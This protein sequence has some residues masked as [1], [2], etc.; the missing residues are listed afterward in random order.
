MPATI[1]REQLVTS[2]LDFLSHQDLLSLA[3]IRA[4]LE[5]EIDGAGSTAL[6][7]LKRQL[8]ADD[9]WNYYP[10]SRLVA[11]IHYLLADHFVR[12]ESDVSGVEHLESIG[13]EPLILCANHLSYADANLVQIL[14]H[15]AGFEDLAQR[16]TALAGPKVFTSRERRFSSL[17]F[18]TVKVP[19]SSDVSSEEAVLSAR[20]VARAARQALSVASQRL[21]A[22]DALVLF[23]EGRRSRSAQMQPMLPAVARY[24]ESRPEAWVVPVGITGTEALFPVGDARVRP[25]RVH[26]RVASPL[27][28]HRV[29]TATNAH[30]QTTMDVV[31]LL[32]ADLL[33]TPYRGVYEKAGVFPEAEQALRALRSDI[34]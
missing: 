6:V 31:G 10:P 29:L 20:D 9:G 16:L 34:P 5:R 7:E 30:R 32:I 15:R 27:R 14:L 1:T 25:A 17:C 26:V 23:G 33:P 8:T 11:H 4:A 18:G 21:A 28:A 24:L 13:S 2:I 22:G 12:P 19:Q 3:H